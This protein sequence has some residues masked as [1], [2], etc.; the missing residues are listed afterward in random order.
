[1]AQSDHAGLDDACEPKA[2]VRPKLHEPNIK[3]LYQ[4]K[5]ART[6]FS[7]FPQLFPAPPDEWS[8][9]RRAAGLR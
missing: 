2:G 1:M 4:G 5:D 6:Y 9:P 7:A 3:H 8:A